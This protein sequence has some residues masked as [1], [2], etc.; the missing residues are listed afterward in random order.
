MQ[1][2][3]HCPCW[4]FLF[5]SGNIGYLICSGHYSRTEIDRQRRQSLQKFMSEPPC[6]NTSGC[7]MYGFWLLW[8]SSLHVI[9]YRLGEEHHLWF[10][11]PEPRNKGQPLVRNIFLKAFSSCF[12]NKTNGRMDRLEGQHIPFVASACHCVIIHCNI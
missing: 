1:P 7:A 5:S 2:V 4:Q 8:T 11:K 9:T 3:K 12:S 6:L 10:L